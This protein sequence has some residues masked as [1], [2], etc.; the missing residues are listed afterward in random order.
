MLTNKSAVVTLSY[1]IYAL[2]LKSLTL[3]PTVTIRD[4][5]KCSLLTSLL[6]TNQGRVW[7]FWLQDQD[8]TDNPAAKLVP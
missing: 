8:M 4:L 7:W 3:G 2:I 6:V 1:I 5:L